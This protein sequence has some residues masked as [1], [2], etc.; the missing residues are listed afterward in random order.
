MSYG[1]NRWQ[2]IALVLIGLAVLVCAV[3][4]D[5]DATLA[6][7]FTSPVIVTGKDAA[8]PGIDIGP[9][10]TLYINAPAG[11]LANLPTAG[12]ASF[13]FRSSDQ[14]A[15]WVETPPGLRAL[16]PGGGDSDV[17]VDPRDGTVY[18]ADLW[19]GN[20]TVAV[21]HDKGNTWVANPL[22]SVIV[23]D[24]QWLATPGSGRAYLATHQV[25]TG[26][27]VSKSVDGGISY[28]QS[29]IA[30]TALDQA[31]CI[32]PSGP[33][34]AEGDGL[35]GLNDLV[36]VI[37]A[38]STGGVKF[39][40]S[41]TGG[42][43]FSSSVVSQSN[44][45]NTATN[46]PVVANAGGKHLVAVWLEVIGNTTRV[47]FNDSFNWGVTWGT[48]RT[49]VSTGTSVYPWIDARGQ[50]IAVTL[51]HTNAS[52]T[53]DTAPNSAQ[54][55]ESYLE[56]ING[57]VSFSALQTIDP[58]AVK[59]GPICTG[60]ANCTANRELLDFQQVLIDRAGRSNATWTRSIDNKSDT[61]IRFARQM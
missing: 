6:A 10:G 28:P 9:D 46:F 48:P 1:T 39:A 40:R 41:T 20:S 52:G 49:L 2:H 56:S 60:G 37:Y 51:Y 53:P 29:S 59:T 8:E 7:S 27:V 44:T 16:F 33:L 26:I 38:T 54:W 61:E 36:G 57:G 22:G 35:L 34:I 11:F 50:K 43:L 17:A 31:G 13:L 30:A 45:A 42:V 58:T 14:G 3:V 23:Q 47:Q 32:C 15:T 12:S 5:P 18:F 4:V 19:V 21:S 24:R 55:F 25:P